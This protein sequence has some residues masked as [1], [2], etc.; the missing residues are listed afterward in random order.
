MRIKA[1]VLCVRDPVGSVQ[2]AGRPE[3]QSPMYVPAFKHQ[4][5]AKVYTF[6]SLRTAP[7]QELACA[8]YSHS[9]ALAW[10]TSA[11]TQRSA[12]PSGMQLYAMV[13]IKNFDLRPP[14]LQR[15]QTMTS[16]VNIGSHAGSHSCKRNTGS[17]RSL[18]IVINARS[19]NK[20][21]SSPF[22]VDGGQS[23]HNGHQQEE[24]HLECGHHDCSEDLVDASLLEVVGR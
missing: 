11:R 16:A 24:D 23:Q 15:C 13:Y 14:I 22:G 21:V 20:E 7:E 19:S 6:T 1:S 2:G 10:L 9:H 3:R 18:G 4:N 12:M 5:V 8:S 17:S